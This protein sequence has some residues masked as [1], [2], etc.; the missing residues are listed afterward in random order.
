[1]TQTFPYQSDSGLGEGRLPFLPM[2]LHR[3]NQRIQVEALVDSGA[4]VNVLP[5]SAGS[6]LGGRWEE[7]HPV[8]LGGNL[9][10]S[11]ARALIVEARV[12]D[13]PVQRL[14]FAW[15]RAENLPVILGQTNFFDCFDVLFRGTRRS[16]TVQLPA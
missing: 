10:S 9:A 16:F 2:E 12:S 14:I 11:E 3:G 5:F 8:R 6:K 4:T 15:S 13:F 7:L 1:M